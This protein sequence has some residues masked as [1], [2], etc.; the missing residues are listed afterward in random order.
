MCFA[1]TGC[2]VKQAVS[3]PQLHSTPVAAIQIG[4]F[5]S[6]ARD[7]AR[8]VKDALTAALLQNGQIRIVENGGD[9]IL[10]GSLALSSGGSSMGMGAAAVGSGGGLG[11]YS[12]A[13]S[14]GVYI[15]NATAKL[16]APNGDLL[17][18]ASLAQ[19][20]DTLLWNGEYSAIHVGQSL[21]KQLLKKLGVKTANKQ[22][23]R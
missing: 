10:K 21:A 22:R 2:A 11:T 16:Y 6:D 17:L 4:E 18:M 19:T 13:G 8:S 15:A 1:L 5:E 23:K 7:V 20:R 12:S 9:A 3:T 14:Q